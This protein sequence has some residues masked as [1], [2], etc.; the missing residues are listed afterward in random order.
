ML[1]GRGER[2][3][4]GIGIDR[5]EEAALASRTWPRVAG[6]FLGL[7]AEGAVVNLERIRRAIAKRK[8][9]ASSFRRRSRWL[10]RTDDGRSIDLSKPK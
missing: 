3:V 1:K 2:P 4:D 5:S 6:S 7:A 8:T 10:C 9:R